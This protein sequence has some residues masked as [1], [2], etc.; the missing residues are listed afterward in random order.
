MEPSK[1]DLFGESA[2]SEAAQNLVSN[3]TCNVYFLFPKLTHNVSQI[4]EWGPVV[5]D[6]TQHQA[7]TAAF[8]KALTR[9]AKET[10]DL[11]IEF[12][13]IMRMK[14]IRK[15][16]FG[17]GIFNDFKSINA[18]YMTENLRRPALHSASESKAFGRKA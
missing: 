7:D 5:E 3:F 8:N 16:N 4:D 11:F 14:S 6:P 15:V 13:E 18:K 10:I 2:L 9:P 1:D 17:L 12:D